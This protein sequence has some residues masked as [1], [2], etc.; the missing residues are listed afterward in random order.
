MPHQ[1]NNLVNSIN[2]FNTVF[3]WIMVPILLVVNMLNTRRWNIIIVAAYLTV[4]GIGLIISGVFKGITPERATKYSEVF[5]DSKNKV[6][7]NVI[8]LGTGLLTLGLGVYLL[9]SQLT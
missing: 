3:A 1:H 4:G 7:K 9:V 2:K 8:R 5:T 6:W